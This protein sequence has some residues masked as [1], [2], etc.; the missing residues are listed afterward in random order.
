MQSFRYLFI[1]GL[2]QQVD[3]V[4]ERVGHDV[5]IGIL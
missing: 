2:Q 3:V 5:I 4:K 1:G